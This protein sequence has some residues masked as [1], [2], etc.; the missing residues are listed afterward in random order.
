MRAVEVATMQTLLMICHTGSAFWLHKLLC[1]LTSW[2]KRCERLTFHLDPVRRLLR[3]RFVSL[4][5]H[6]IAMVLEYGD[7]SKSVLASSQ[8]WRDCFNS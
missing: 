4:F 1:F 3:V 2:L 6:P 7:W 8:Q 5:P